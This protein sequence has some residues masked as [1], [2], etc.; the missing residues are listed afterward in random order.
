MR[1]AHVHGDGED[2]VLFPAVRAVFPVFEPSV[3][4]EHAA[5]HAVMGEIEAAA[6]V[7][8]AS[9]SSS[10][11]VVHSALTTLATK[12]P[13]WGTHMLDHMRHE[14]NSI[15]VVARKYFALDRAVELTRAVYNGTSPSDWAVVLPWVITHL[16]HPGW[17]ARFVRSFAWAMPDRAQELGLILYRGCDSAVYASLVD[18]IPEIAPRGTPGWRREY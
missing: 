2:N 3:D 6:A 4:A 11:A 18:E 13:A 7:L 12:F 15:T 10:S 5:Q 1:V 16:P 9:D 14:E 17:K 8:R